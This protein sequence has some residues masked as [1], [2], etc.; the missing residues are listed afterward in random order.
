M[1]HWI[2]ILCLLASSATALSQSYSIEYTCLDGSSFQDS[3]LVGKVTLIKFWMPW[4]KPCRKSNAQ[5]NT[6]YSELDSSERASFQVVC[7]AL[8]T[9]SANWLKAIEFDYLFDYQ[10]IL[11]TL[12]KNSPVYSGFN[13]TGLPYSLVFNQNGELV[14]QGLRGSILFEH[15]E[16]LL[17]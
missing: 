4:C 6:F 17:E 13:G 12:G 5:L 10:H 1:R 2:A 7:I 15:V 11:D 8:E 14:H 9:D 16:K 3:S